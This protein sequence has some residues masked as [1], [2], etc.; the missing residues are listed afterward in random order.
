VLNVISFEDIDTICWY[1]WR[2]WPPLFKLSFHNN[3]FCHFHPLYKEECVCLLSIRVLRLWNYNPYSLFYF[4]LGNCPI[5]DIDSMGFRSSSSFLRVHHMFEGDKHHTIK[6]NAIDIF[7][8]CK[9]PQPIFIPERYNYIVIQIVFK[10]FFIV[11]F[12]RTKLFRYVVCMFMFFIIDFNRLKK[13]I[14]CMSMFLLLILA[15]AKICYMHFH[16]FII[17]F[18]I[19][20]KNMVNIVFCVLQMGFCRLL[21]VYI[22]MSSELICFSSKIYLH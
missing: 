4:Y 16:A 17:D 13:Y 15:V 8:I 1:R 21:H 3:P 7:C 14:G 6:A 2:C 12:R 22:L 20:L 11:N 19:V 18:L 9:Y 5:Y 10:I